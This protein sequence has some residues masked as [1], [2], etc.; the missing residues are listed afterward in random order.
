MSIVLCF[1]FS[2]GLLLQKRKD[3]LR[4]GGY[5]KDGTDLRVLLG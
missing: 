4:G 3:K 5:F 2:S 1:T